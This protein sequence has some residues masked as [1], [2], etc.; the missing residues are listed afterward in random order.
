MK[1]DKHD[2]CIIVDAFFVDETGLNPFEVDTMP[3]VFHPNLYPLN[4]YMGFY[5]VS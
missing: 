5:V 4:G 1:M 3:S 2:T